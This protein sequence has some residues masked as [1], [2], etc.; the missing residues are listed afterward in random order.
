MDELSELIRS[1]GFYLQEANFACVGTFWKNIVYVWKHHRIYY[2]ESGKALMTLRSATLELEPGNLYYI[3]QNSVVTAS[4][5]QALSHYYIHFIPNAVGNTLLNAFPVFCKGVPSRP[6]DK[7]IF[8]TIIDVYNKPKLS[9]ASQLFLNGYM[10]ILLSRF[11]EKLDPSFDN[12]NVF[13]FFDIIHYIDT[14]IEKKIT[15]KQLA[16]MANLNEVY[17]SN[18]FSKIIGRSPLQ[19]IIEKKLQHAMHLMQDERL[20][21]KE[22]AFQLNFSDELYFSRLFKKKNGISPSEFRSFLASKGSAE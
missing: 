7:E 11:V 3:P 17:F 14:N 19:Y 5:T 12:Q 10:Q 18:C 4:N 2:I 9:N 6:E 16:S 8:K 15:V 20:S 13:R 21:I 22:I 1:V